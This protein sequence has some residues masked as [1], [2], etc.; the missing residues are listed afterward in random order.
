M[1]VLFGHEA[2]K[3]RNGSVECVKDDPRVL[4]PAGYRVQRPKMFFLTGQEQARECLKY[5]WRGGTAWVGCKFGEF[6]EGDQCV[7]VSVED[8][9]K[10][11]E[12]ISLGFKDHFGNY[13]PVRANVDFCAVVSQSFPELLCVVHDIAE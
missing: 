3:D 9:A 10:P 11:G 2:F 8:T 12:L 4:L 1:W 5:D 13:I 7:V 6:V